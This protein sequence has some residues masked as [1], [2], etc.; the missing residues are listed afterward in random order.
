MKKVLLAAAIAFAV[1]SS[2]AA[3]YLYSNGAAVRT[4][5]RQFNTAGELDAY[6]SETGDDAILVDLRD[7]ADFEKGHAPNFLNIAWK[8][9]GE[10][11]RTWITPYRRD[12]PVVLICY[13]GNRSARAFEALVLLGFTRI[14]DFSPGYAEYAAQKGE[15]FKP[16]LG[17]CDCPE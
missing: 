12:K 5:Y 4:D 2:V 3:A 13:G 9:S 15:G 14:A 17:S 8:D 1:L 7:R 11:F 16:E 10:L 6:L